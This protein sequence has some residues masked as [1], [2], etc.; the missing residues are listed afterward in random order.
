MSASDIEYKFVV[1]GGG[2]VGKSSLTCMLCKSHFIEVYDP[3][4]E[5]SYRTQFETED[6][7]VV[8]LDILDTAGQ[9]DYSAMREQYM[10]SGQGFLIVY[11]ITSHQSFEECATFRTQ[12]CRT[13][14]RDELDKTPA[15]VV[16]VG[17]KSDL[18]DQRKVTQREATEFAVSSGWKHIE[19]SAKAH[20]NVEEA[21]R[22]MVKAVDECDELAG[23]PVRGKKK[24]KA[25]GKRRCSVM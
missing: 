3:T 19:T 8:V 22:L 13:L 6:G 11:S 15:P 24:A 9:E 16:L 5:D 18:V 23:R 4:I 7:R 21:F 25:S 1:M 14:D 10:R 20:Y 12:L 2:A 17:N